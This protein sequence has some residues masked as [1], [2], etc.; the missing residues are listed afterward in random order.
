LSRPLALGTLAL[1]AV[2]VWVLV[3]AGGLA[4]SN[5]AHAQPPQVALTASYSII[6]G[7]GVGVQDNLT[8]V[9]DG[10]QVVVPLTGS[11]TVYMADA[12]TGWSAQTILTGST[13]SERWITTQDV[14]GTI[15]TPLT[16]SFSY[17]HQYQVNFNY[18]V[19]HGG[20]GFTGPLVSYDQMG[21]PASSP[22]PV[23][24]WVDASSPYSYASQLPGSTSSERW[25]LPSGGSGTVTQP[26]TFVETY[27]HEYLVSSSFSIVN[28]GAPTPPTLS[29]TALGAPAAV[30]M[31]SF[32]QN[33]WFDAGANYTFTAPLTE[34]SQP[35]NETWV[36]TVLVQTQSGQV[37]SRDN[38]GTVT[39]PIS[40]TPVFY[41]Q[42]FV[43]VKFKLVGG[44]L[45]SLTP[46]AFTYQ[47]FGNKASV[48]KNTSV[49][50]DS[51]T[52]Y[53]VPANICCT[54]PSAERWLLYNATSGTISFPTKISMTYFHQYF[55]SFS[56]SILGDQPP[57][58]SGQ[59]GVTYDA[60]GNAQHLTLLLTPQTFWADANSTYSATSTLSAS[61]GTE[62]WFSPIAMGSIKGPAPNNSVNIDYDQQ[63]LVTMVGGGLPAE[64]LSAG[65]STTLSAP[66]VFGRSQGTGYRVTSYQIDSGST[67]LVSAPIGLLFIPLSMNGPHTITFQSVTQF[68]VSLDVGAA[69]GL[70]FITPPTVAGDDY[71]YDSGSQV[72]VVLNGA[73]GRTDG[74]GHRI[75]SISAS[76]QSTVTVDT[77]GTVQAYFASSLI[78]PVSITT[79][80]LTQYEV[81][82]NGAALSAF[83]SIS[84]PSTFPN[85]TFW[86]DTGSPAVTLVLNG[87]YSRSAGT[88]VRTSAW[89]LDSG[90]VTKVAQTGPI[91]IVTKAMTAAQFVNAT[92]VTQYQV[93]LDAK[94]GSALA[95]MTSPSIP[96]DSGWYDA[97]G[98]M[99]LI[100]NGAWGRGAGTGHRLAGYS[101]NGGSEVAVASTG[102]VE[103]LNLTSISS[104]EA[105][106]TT[107]VTQFQV[108]LD[109]GAS[110]S[111]SSITPT[112]VPKDKYWYDAGTAVA[113][114][115]NGVWGRTAT[116]GDR[117]L[118]YS[119]NQG[120]ST[121]VLSSSPVQVFSV[122]AI[123][124]PESITTKANTQFRVTSPVAWVS[125]T[126][127]TVPGDAGWF[128]TATKVNV[129]FDSV[130][131][132]T[133]TG[134]RESVTSYTING[135]GKTGVARSGNG[136]FSIALS[137]TQAQ[138]IALT[139]VTQY[140]LTVVGPPQMTAAPPSPTG[141]SYFDSG[142]KVTLTV[143]RAWNGT[144][145]AG[146]RETLTSFSLDGAAPTSVLPSNSSASFTTAA[147]TFNQA[148]TLEFSTVVQYQVAFQFLDGL[149]TSP[150]Q[151]SVVQLRVGNSTVDVEG[152]SFWLGNG[153]SFTVVN[154]T[155]EGANV[156]PEPPPSYQVKAAPLNVTLDTKVYQ[157]SLKVVDLF[158][159]PVSGA[160]VS[161]TLANGTT[162][163]G[164]TNGKGVFSAG[165]IPVGT[166]TAKVTS[167][168]TSVR[169]SGDAASGQTVAVGKVPLSLVSLFVV[170]AAAA[171][172]GSAGV[173]F[174]RRRKRAKGSTRGVS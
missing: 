89:E 35:A 142:S 39:G 117:L 115:L 110:S 127:S 93:T 5:V 105:V 86:Y 50:V 122:S 159:L 167:L 161:M 64:W 88:G 27:Y 8:Y 26:A 148:H 94:G 124:G 128:D 171:G 60:G 41:H 163:T 147:L 131:N 81:V 112:P 42:F 166:Y 135:G 23:L 4:S 133:S 103:V 168:G 62:R 28:G 84:P 107:V 87:A 34:P 70:H 3:M 153:T 130:W 32:T 145:G 154:V 80:S 14:S 18:N 129:V 113:V 78:S 48:S 58:P 55:D 82:L 40:I 155:W 165:A 44:T 17:Y 95:S 125:I 74:V 20:T 10:V 99:G 72:Q 12:G 170:V 157:A 22:A 1:A 136:T 75:T 144:S 151:P 13:N 118:S 111:L 139:S 69:G 59:P 67:V 29:S 102:L 141:D 38:N 7:T 85:D 36:G 116:A 57:S 61:N 92:S 164:V 73:W 160:Q 100:L 90:P 158:G 56:Y 104:P 132:Q 68:E 49:W 30:G 114:S 150:V 79:T 65:N 97:S 37:L 134:S 71:W 156:G 77:L 119:V 46:P 143:P 47:Y 108:T 11:P 52:Q 31:T 98:P 66:G 21:A 33:T 106:T 25:V 126:N 6:G 173:L 172:A 137:M 63:Y 15:G 51:G 16:V 109:S 152:P 43:G 53:S 174:M 146:S 96:L 101:L 24:A 2:A 162:L 123:S 91:T 149:G 54:D 76:G 169:I 138:S 45:G 19:T 9:S 140:L 83:S 121:S 120:A